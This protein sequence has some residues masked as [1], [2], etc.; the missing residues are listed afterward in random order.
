MGMEVL[1]W[2]KGIYLHWLLNMYE[3][4]P[5]K[6]SFFLK[7]NFFDLLAG[8]DTLRLEILAGKKEREIRLGWEKGIE[9]FR[10]TREKYLLYPDF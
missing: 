9:Q 8:T 10:K 6:S 7:N 3:A 5:D 2:R 1:P 4:Y